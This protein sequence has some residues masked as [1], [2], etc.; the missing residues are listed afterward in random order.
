MNPPNCLRFLCLQ[1]LV[2]MCIL[3]IVVIIWS[4]RSCSLD[5]QISYTD[6]IRPDWSATWM[7]QYFL[8]LQVLISMCIL[9]IVLIWSHRSC[10]LARQIYWLT[11]RLDILKIEGLIKIEHWTVFENFFICSKNSKKH[12]K[13]TYCK[14][15]YS[16]NT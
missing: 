15:K 12:I 11:D 3:L 7:P 14:K 4:R 8:Y 9:L 16:K 2:S 10:S 1:V 13:N 5:R 6:W